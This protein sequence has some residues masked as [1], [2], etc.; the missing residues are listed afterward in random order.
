VFVS[1]PLSVSVSVSVYVY[2]CIC[3]CL[4]L[5]VGGRV[6]GWAGGCATSRRRLLDFICVTHTRMRAMTH[7]LCVMTHSH[8]CR[9]SFDVR[10]DLFA[11]CVVWCGWCVPLVGD[12]LYLCV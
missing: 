7:D 9:D 2:V 12:N 4:G 5:W 10:H 11:Y 1:L 3:I 6:G 8:V